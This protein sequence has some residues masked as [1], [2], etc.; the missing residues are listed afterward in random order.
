MITMKELIKQSLF[1]KPGK[2]EKYVE[3]IVYKPLTKDTD[4]NYMTKE[5]IKSMSDRFMRLL[6]MGKAE[7]DLLHNGIAGT[8]YLSKSYIDPEGSWHVGVKIEDDSTW[9]EIKKGVLKG[10]SLWGKSEERSDGEIVNPQVSKISL[11]DRPATGEH[12][13]LVKSEKT[14]KDKLYN[15][16]TQLFIKEDTMENNIEQRLETLEKSISSIETSLKQ[17][18]LSKQAT[19]Q[20]EP[21]QVD[22]QSSIEGRLSSIEA[23]NKDI[24]SQVAYLTGGIPQSATTTVSKSEKTAEQTDEE[25]FTFLG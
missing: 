16:V 13:S 12:F 9:Q 8:G 2:D 3:G 20:A 24:S 1:D 5:T 25:L 15:L 7:I 19:G 17:I 4:G 22:A 21:A 11:V 23:V 14:I 10:F 6:S 18:A